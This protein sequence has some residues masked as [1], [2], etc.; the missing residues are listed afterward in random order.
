MLWKEKKRGRG[1][2]KGGKKIGKRKKTGGGA[3]EG[4]RFLGRYCSWYT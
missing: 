3:R 1:E 2:K 4:G